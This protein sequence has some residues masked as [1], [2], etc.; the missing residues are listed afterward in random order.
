MRSCTIFWVNI[1]SMAEVVRHGR[2]RWFGH[3][4]HKSGDDWV[5]ACR[6]VVV[7]QGRDVWVEAGR[8][9]EKKMIRMSLVCT[10]NGQCCSGICGK[11]SYR[12][13]RLTLAERGRNG[14]FKN[15]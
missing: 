12:E 9:G 14:C 3:V 7:W 8:L 6:N 1:Q 13:K 4:E 11:A 5:S 15:K 10:L 2:L